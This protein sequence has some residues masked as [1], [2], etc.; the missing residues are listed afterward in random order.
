MFPAALLAVS[1]LTLPPL[2]QAP[3]VHAQTNSPAT[4]LPTI[5]GGGGGDGPG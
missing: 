1:L 3:Q 4:G 5:S 2:F